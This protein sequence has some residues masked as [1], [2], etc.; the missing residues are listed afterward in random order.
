MSNLV[1]SARIVIDYANGDV[2]TTALASG[3]EFVAAC[4]PKGEVAHW[5][6]FG[7]VKAAEELRYY[8]TEQHGGEAIVYRFPIASAGRKEFLL[9]I[10]V[11]A[12]R[13]QP[14]DIKPIEFA[15]S[16]PLQAVIPVARSMAWVS[17]V[18]AALSRGRLYDVATALS[19]FRDLPLREELGDLAATV[20]VAATLF[21]RIVQTELDFVHTASRK[22]DL[23][24]A[25]QFVTEGYFRTISAGNIASV[26]AD[27]TRPGSFARRLELLDVLEP[28]RRG[29]LNE[30][31]RSSYGPDTNRVFVIQTSFYCK[32]AADELAMH[33][34]NEAFALLFKGYECLAIWEN[35][36][37]GR[38]YFFEHRVWKSDNTEFKGLGAMW[39]NV[40]SSL[41]SRLDLT[42]YKA[43]DD[44]IESRNVSRIGHGL[45]VPSVG[46]VAQQADLLTKYVAATA[47]TRG[48]TDYYQLLTDALVVSGFCETV[49]SAIGEHLLKEHRLAPAA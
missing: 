26:R 9:R 14:E 46:V 36:A 49:S 17:S 45:A 2:L 13:C 19:Q 39:G 44:F 6:F 31:A 28:T 42:S 4:P 27:L 18:F 24:L 33:R 29:F 8:A 15:G 48:V 47:R 37:T 20:S 21:S 12:L 32:C 23:F 35:V 16:P 43:V 1:V 38:A 25:E 10:L 5:L 11:M 30:V 40:K 22:H 3:P 7:S 34:P 41:V